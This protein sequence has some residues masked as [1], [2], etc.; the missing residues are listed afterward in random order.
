[1]KSDVWIFVLEHLQ[2]HRK[3][4]RNSPTFT[5]VDAFDFEARYLLVF[6]QDWSQTADLRA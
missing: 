2:E 6:S 5:L 3:K 1:M 4:M